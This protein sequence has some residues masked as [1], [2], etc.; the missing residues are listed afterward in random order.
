VIARGTAALR[1]PR[2]AWAVLGLAMLCS[3]GLIL[4]AAH[5]QGFAID[6]LFY[7]GRVASVKG[8]LVH[9][10]P[11]SPEYLLAPF[12]GHLPLGGRFVYELVF[13]T[14]GA[15][16]TVFVLIDIAALWAVVGLVFELAR[17]RVGAAA[18][19]AP[20]VVLLFL[21]FAR[22][23]LLWPLDFNTAAS[24][25]A[26]LGAVLAIQRRDRRGDLLACAL[27]AVSIAMI[28]LGLAFALGIALWL[29]I[30]RPRPRGVLDRAWLREVLRRAW[31]VAIPV[32]LYA[33]WYVW[34]R[35]FG[36]SET[37][38]GNAHL[39]P[40]TFMHGAAAAFGSLTGTNPIVAGTY[41]GSVTWFGRALAV[42]AGVALLVRIW[43]RRLP[44]TIWVWLL[45]L[46]VYWGLLAIAARPAEGSRYILVAAALIVLIAADSVRRRLPD[47][48]AV[49]LLVLA[50]VALPANI[51][52]LTKDRGSDTLHHDPPVSGTEFAM[53]ELARRHVD[54]EY[55]VTADPRVGE[56]DGGL[57]I[58]I[59]A[60]AYL[61]SASQNGSIARSLAE[62][63]E[64]DVTLRQIA[65]A[66]LIGA[67]G[68][69]TKPGPPPGRGASCRTI[70]VAPGAGSV[71]FEVAA[72]TTL[73]RPAGS[74][75]T[76]L[77]LARFADP[78]GIG[79]D[80]MPPG[81]WTELAIPADEAPDPWRVTV[82]HPTVACA[83]D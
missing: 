35:K 49:A 65:D 10:A 24:L 47:P 55:V 25:A 51:V 2:V 6:E 75:K 11:F 69:E 1:E 61:D 60:G 16:Y 14:L 63:R 73:L 79:I 48:A 74:E 33:A 72:G 4:H 34:A 80:Y 38:S 8:Q 43:G 23:Q 81:R 46:A 68:V 17:R 9:Y 18:A 83:P 67:L 78:P 71:S 50:A 52:Q 19:L 13:A 28:E 53:L 20:C 41:V 82:D 32:V 22:E 64:S 21:G 30:S 76:G 66:S 7:Y 15:H 36:Q 12:N 77:W 29:V 45:V 54:P 59:P 3:G 58:G 5:G 62:V 57:F 39:L 70:A 37:H 31:I 56:V 42:A 44:R 40:E 27:L 26:G